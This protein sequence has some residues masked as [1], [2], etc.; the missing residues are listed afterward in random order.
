MDELSARL[1]YL[2]SGLNFVTTFGLLPL[3]AGTS[4][5]GAEAA[6]V[7]VY[8]EAELT[9]PR[10]T[11]ATE[12]W[13]EIDHAFAYRGDPSGGSGMELTDAQEA[14]LR[15]LQDR[16]RVYVREFME[17][18]SVIYAGGCRGLPGYPVFWGYRLLILN[19]TREGLLLFGDASD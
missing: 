7:Q 14:E 16:Y 18:V 10:R 8:P 5:E 4:L 9:G 15:E 1:E 3:P 19:P 2:M 11:D 13:E 6:I 12:V 17:P